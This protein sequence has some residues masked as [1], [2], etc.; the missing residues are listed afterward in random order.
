MS[1]FSSS[2]EHNSQQFP[3]KGGDADAIAEAPKFL[4][5]GIRG[6]SK[7]VQKDVYNLFS[8][9]IFGTIRT[10]VEENSQ[11]SHLVCYSWTTFVDVLVLSCYVVICSVRAAKKAAKNTTK[12]N[13]T[14]EADP[15]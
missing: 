10:E 4:P 3:Q 11:Y 2:K 6:H 8:F 1:D 7:C 15:A 14:N 12:T 13:L 5:H 9:Y